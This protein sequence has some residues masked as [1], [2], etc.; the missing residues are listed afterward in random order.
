MNKKILASMLI[1]AVAA[2]LIGAGTIS[3]FND[4]ETSKNNIFI[5]GTIDLRIRHNDSD[6]WTD[7][8]TA[9][10]TVPDMKP[11]D[12]LG[13]RSIWFKNFGTIQ[14]STMTITCNYTVTEE[15]PQT[16]ADTDPNTDQHP[17]AMAKYM[18][19]THIHYRNDLINIDC[20]TGQ[21]STNP[22]NEDWRINDTDSD[23][24][25]TLYDLK[26]D[27]LINLP[28][29]DTQPNG[30]TQLDIEL[31]FDLGAGDDFQGDTF[32]LTLIFTLNQ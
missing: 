19:I 20:L 11:G 22:P 3:Y 24:K 21:N 13:F 17:D 2:A 28:S 29:P 23:G 14:T 5:D 1:I 15:T 10:W 31:K 4:V 8:V 7:G 32:N 16:E 25:I 9:T 27:P 30:I 26:M 18:I 6:P 12:N